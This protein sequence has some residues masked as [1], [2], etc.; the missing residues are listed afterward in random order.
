MQ[1]TKELIDKQRELLNW[2]EMRLNDLESFD[3]YNQI[4]AEI[5]ALES[6]LSESGKGLGKGDA[7]DIFL[8][9]IDD[10]KENDFLKRQQ[11]KLRT[12]NGI[13]TDYGQH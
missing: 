4:K 1:T 7:K 5:K 2:L 11:N 12:C 8:K 13:D 3:K 6:S 9:Q 10:K